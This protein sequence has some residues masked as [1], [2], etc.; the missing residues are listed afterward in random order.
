M[1]RFIK[2][3]DGLPSAATN[4]ASGLANGTASGKGVTF[5]RTGR[6]L[7]DNPARFI[8]NVRFSYDSKRLG[9]SVRKRQQPPYIVCSD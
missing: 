2:A 1:K 3:A 4:K 7:S 8:D 6:V 9:M 5:E